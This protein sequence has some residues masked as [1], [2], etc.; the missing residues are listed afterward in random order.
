MTESAT[1]TESTTMTEPTGD[2]ILWRR[3][4]GPGHDACRLLEGAAGWLLEGTAVFQ[5]DRGRP[6]CLHY[7]VRCDRRWHTESGRVR[8]W[9]GERAVALRVERDAAGRWLLNDEL[10]PG[11]EDQVDLDLGFTPATNLLQLRRLQLQIGQAA[12]APAAWLDVHGP[13]LTRLVQRYER[14]SATAYGYR[15]PEVGYEGELQVA[16]SGFVRSYPGLWVVEG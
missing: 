13:S 6:T 1:M 4:D 12:D 8:G 15:A 9:I 10:V 16:P 3:L 2:S 7:E 11:L 5:D 14:R